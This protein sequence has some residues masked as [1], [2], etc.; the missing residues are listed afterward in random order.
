MAE[1]TPS[2]NA[3]DYAKNSSAQATWAYELVAR[4]GLQGHESLIDIGCGDG[5]I[6]DQI[7]ARLAGGSVVGIDSSESMITLAA[8][9][10]Q[11]PNLAFFVMDA[12]QIALPGR[13]FD[14]AFSNAALHWVPDHRAVLQTLAAHLNP[15]AR[16][17]FQMGGRGNA[18]GIL[19]ALRQLIARPRWTPFFESFT[20]P[21]SF[22]DITDYE[23]WLPEAGYRPLRIQ[24]LPKDMTHPNSDGLKGWL[25]TTWF[26]YTNRL[27]EDLKETFLTELV[28][29][30]LAAHPLDAAGQTHV[31]MIRLEVEAEWPG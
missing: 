26:P 6:T 28:E 14:V 15:G 25:R 27:P 20:F 18:A 19:K 9:S 13:R 29:T 16:L 17:L 12:A 4:L 21:Y 2:W 30:Y 10:F 22:Y 5:K 24:L 1:A 31:E 3:Q 8:Q 11:R 7:A 23:S